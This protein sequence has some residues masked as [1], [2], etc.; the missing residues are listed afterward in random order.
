[1]NRLSQGITLVTSIFA[2]AYFAMRLLG[3]GAAAVPLLGFFF[4]AMALGGTVCLWQAQR[5]RLAASP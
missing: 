3:Q 5:S 4:G 1:V 2:C